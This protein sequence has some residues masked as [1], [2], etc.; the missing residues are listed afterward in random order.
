MHGLFSSGAGWDGKNACLIEAAP[1]ELVC[2]MPT[3]HF[4]PAEIKKRAGKG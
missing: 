3:I 4:K 1:M 2:P